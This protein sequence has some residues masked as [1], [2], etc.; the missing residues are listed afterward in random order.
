MALTVNVA[1]VERDPISGR[2]LLNQYEIIDELGRGV[3]GK[4]KLG[5]NLEKNQDVAIKIVDRYSKRRRLGKLGDPEDN[6]KK[7]VAILKKAIHPNVVA[8][9]EVIDDPAKKKVY[10]V[11][12]Y[13]QLGEIPWRRKGVRRIVKIERQ[14][15]EREC[16]EQAENLSALEGQ[17]VSGSAGYRRRDEGRF[18]DRSQRYYGDV[19]SYHWSLEHGGGSDDEADGGEETTNIRRS[20]KQPG[21]EITGT[22]QV[23]GGGTPSASSVRSHTRSPSHSTRMAEHFSSDL[24]GRIQ[25]I[26]A[27]MSQGQTS[28]ES[29]PR[30]DSAPGPRSI[31]GGASD[32]HSTPASPGNFL[33]ILPIDFD[34]DPYEEHFS[35]VPCLSIDQAR[36]AFRD[37]VLGLEYLHYQGI[38][39]RDIKPANLLWTHEHQVKISDFGV[40]YLGRPIRGDDAGEDLSEADAQPLDEAVELAKTVGTPAFHAPELCYTDLTKPRPPV[41]GQIDLWALGVTLYCL[42][43]AR[44]PFFAE[45]EFSL[46]KSIADDAVCIPR[47][48]LKAIDPHPHFSPSSSR[49]GS[50]ISEVDRDYRPDSELIYEDIDD[51][52]YDLLKRILEKDPTKRI[53]LKE[54]KRHPFTLKGLSDPIRWIEETDPARKYEGKKIEVSS[55]DVEKAVVPI[56]FL[57]RVRSG[58]RR[59]GAAIGLGTPRSGRRRAH[60][61]TQSHDGASSETS[62]SP[63]PTIR[64]D[65]R[66]SL[67]GGDDFTPGPLRFAREGEHPLSQSV[68]A[69]PEPEAEEGCFWQEPSDIDSP[70]QPH[71]MESSQTEPGNSLKPYELERT[72]STS[73][74]STRTII[75]PR[76]PEG[77][78]MTAPLGSPPLPDYPTAIGTAGPSNVLGVFRATRRDS[79][80]YGSGS[81]EEERTLAMGERRT[82]V[83]DIT[84][85]PL[86][87]LRVEPSVAISNELA[88]GHVDSPS[89]SNDN[90]PFRYNM[91]ES[92]RMLPPPIPSRISS[93]ASQ[94]P[95][96]SGSGSRRHSASPVSPFFRSITPGFREREHSGDDVRPSRPATET[97]SQEL[98]PWRLRAETEYSR[99]SPL[100]SPGPDSRRGRNHRASPSEEL[101]SQKQLEGDFRKIEGDHQQGR[102]TRFPLNYHPYAL[103]PQSISSSSEDHF[104]SGMSPSTSYPSIPSMISAGSSISAEDPAI[105]HS[106]LPSMISPPLPLPSA[107][108]PS[109]KSPTP[110]LEIVASKPDTT[111]IDDDDD[112]EA[113]YNGD[114]AI[115]TDDDEEQERDSDD[116]DDGD[117]LVMTRRKSRLAG[118]GGRHGGRGSGGRGSGG[119]GRSQSVSEVESLRHSMVRRGTGTSLK[120]NRSGSS[121][122]TLRN[123]TTDPNP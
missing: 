76:H 62:T 2:K 89:Y 106:R 105:S 110:P 70:E 85:N 71:T 61:N 23:G 56:G 94:S 87:D 14:R 77:E 37:T 58:M 119:A 117:F 111:K 74:A 68:T 8:L 22:E 46:F 122:G 26:R 10:I 32:R 7:E 64:E 20:D 51:D 59:M 83:L 90:I 67:R 11:L 72:L 36:R 120:T 25:D 52:L 35:Y 103:P 47:R 115:E 30:Y 13:V 91:F 123:T 98:L 49:L 18:G 75:A 102:T 17:G 99:G 48:R 5:R 118:G 97:H 27:R 82:P 93:S 104:T 54:V 78:N 3:Q 19:S 121:G 57:A 63:T 101:R 1:D 69:S 60:S 95:T 108:T 16:Q 80:I 38:I 50:P 55:E 112:D 88:T 84:R 29:L 41:T 92:G 44:V 28:R 96:D 15:Y 79:N 33:S 21:A 43:F 6:V 53:T 9:L 81:N 66:S 24:E 42:L 100:N 73:T 107:T 31:T 86:D 4:V 39:H 65:R 114:T 40:S 113:G 34:Y 116:A 109:K 12:E 45:D